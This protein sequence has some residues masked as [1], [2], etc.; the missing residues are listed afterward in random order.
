MET[1]NTVQYGNISIDILLDKVNSDRDEIS[2]D[3]KS[4]GY[5]Q[6]GVSSEEITLKEYKGFKIGDEVTI[7]EKPE[8]WNASAGIYPYDK[9]PL[10]Q[11]ECVTE[12]PYKGKINALSADFK[13]D[14][15]NGIFKLIGLSHV[16]IGINGFGF[17]LGELIDCKLIKSKHIDLGDPASLSEGDSDILDL[18]DLVIGQSYRIKSLEWIQSNKN[19][20]IISKYCSNQIVYLDDINGEQITLNK[21][22]D[23]NSKSCL[24]DVDISV[25]KNNNNQFK[26]SKDV[27]K[28]LTKLKKEKIVYGYDGGPGG[29]RNEIIKTEDAL[30]TINDMIYLPV[31]ALKRLWTVDQIT[32]L[33][34]E[35]ET[36]QGF[37]ATEYSYISTEL[38]L[39]KDKKKLTKTSSWSTMR[40]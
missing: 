6:V 20:H 38:R 39:I 22:A 7:L 30:P 16:G 2:N 34:D 8:M 9:I 4:R 24:V 37:Q 36:K 27:K 5:D 29:G 17:A 40:D 25:I 21:N 26:I 23:L 1:L 18:K 15:I 12:Y 19:K 10:G 32:Q 14:D 28:L 11:T 13:S 31:G 33:F 3:F 35:G